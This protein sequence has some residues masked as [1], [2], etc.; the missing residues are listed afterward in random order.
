ME[1]R[2]WAKARQELSSISPHNHAAL[3]I[4]DSALFVVVLDDFV[5]KNVD[6]AVSNMLHGTYKLQ[7]CDTTR[8]SQIGTCCNRWYDKLQIIV[9]SDGTAGINFEHSSIDGHTALRFA[10]D[11]FAETIVS[12]AQSITKTIYGKDR[13]PAVLKAP[14]RKARSYSSSRPYSLDGKKSLLDTRPKRIDIELSR[15]V[16]DKIFYA[17]ANLGDSLV[18][19]KTRVLEFKSF[20][21]LFITANNMS[22]DSFVQ[23]AI[24]LS[25]YSLYGKVVC[26]YEPVLMKRFLHGRTEA[27]RSAIPHAALLCETWCSNAASNEQK[28]SALRAAT[29]EHSSIVKECASGKGVERHL[30]ALKCISD[31]HNLPLPSFFNSNAWQT[32]NHTILSTSNCGN[33]SLRHFGFGPVVPD[34]FGI[35]YIIKDQTLHFS[36]SSRN[37]QTDRYR[38]TLL[39]VLCQ[40]ESMLAPT[41]K[42]EVLSNAMISRANSEVF[43]ADGYDEYQDI[44]ESPTKYSPGELAK[45]R[46]SF[47]I[48]SVKLRPTLAREELETVGVGLSSKIIMESDTI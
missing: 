44:P 26:Q 17:E 28:L 15:S 25:Y 10:S 32:L 13:I 31:R 11:V 24:L 37:R 39:L 35:G 1:R 38:N 14:I 5:P 16:V 48:A 6:E 4:I 3:R 9:C 42:V 45:R 29:N 36:I 47:L 40:V 43:F 27:M 41:M 21:K 20:G 7:E 33:P 8:Q 2:I 19:A 23:M 46:S 12:F 34:G 22:P 18:S 30:F